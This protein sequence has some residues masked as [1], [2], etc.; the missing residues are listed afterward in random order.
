MTGL[1]ILLATA[2]VG[3][4]AAGSY[5]LNKRLK[6][7]KGIGKSISK[8]DVQPENTEIIEEETPKTGQ[9]EGT[10]TVTS[11]D[12]TNTAKKKKKKKEKK[13]RKNK[14]DKKSKTDKGTLQK[15]KPEKKKT[16]GK[17]EKKKKGNNTITISA[18]EY[19]EI[20]NAPHTD[21]SEEEKQAILA[22]VMQDERDEIMAEVMQDA[23]DEIMAEIMQDAQD[24]IMAE[25]QQEEYE[26]A[27]FPG[28][29]DL[30]TEEIVRILDQE[31]FLEKTI[32]GKIKYEP[33]DKFLQTSEIK[34]FPIVNMP[35]AGTDVLFPN[36]GSIRPKG[37]MEHIF[38]KDLLS[39]FSS[40]IMTNH[41]LHFKGAENDYEPD[42]IFK[43]R[44]FNLLVD[45]E[46]DEPYSGRTRKPM[47]YI[48][49]Y[50]IDRDR[51]FNTN[52]WV[53]IRFAEEQIVRQPRACGKF[54]AQ[55]I[56]SLIETNFADSF[57]QDEDLPT[58]KQWT[59]DEA[60]KMAEEKY[61]ESYLGITFAE[62][63]DLE[64]TNI[65]TEEEIEKPDVGEESLAKIKTRDTETAHVSL[66]EKER[67]EIIE[68]AIESKQYLKFRYSNG[69][70]HLVSPKEIKKKRTVPVLIAFDYVDNVNLEFE[71]RLIDTL[72][73]EKEPFII[74]SKYKS[75]DNAREI[76]QMAIDNGLYLR[77][78]Y[79]NYHGKDSLRT[80]GFFDYT[81]E[82]DIW[83]YERE[84]FS[85]MC[86]FR[87]EKRSFKI[88]RIRHLWVLSLSFDNQLA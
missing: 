64:I 35:T 3:S 40:N 71:V 42:F 31:P 7:E 16:T 59:Y 54:I 21:L 52:G 22:E 47:H 45:I 43:N 15:K 27:G 56:D 68:R 76:L 6:K 28:F 9:K 58:I 62:Q 87:K 70:I 78:E 20:I 36:H 51:Y 80:I 73:M 46:I 11:P 55:V 2:I 82:F 66:D 88:E 23:Q 32:F 53:T 30:S 61:R 84:H 12:K 1:T 33:N 63:K 38:V 50:G 5:Y 86:F 4:I 10:K 19:E 44:E 85:G 14:D 29:H 25:I 49:S 57:K 77:F 67:I 39:W 60:K 24:E 74:D 17:K 48:G 13:E 83:G 79:T 81:D 72:V 26:A 34:N 75:L 65:E 37:Y 8:K 69:L 18:E 41:H